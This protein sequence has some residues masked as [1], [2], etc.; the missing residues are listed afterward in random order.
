M[1]TSSHD[2]LHHATT[3]ALINAMPEGLLQALDEALSRGRTREELL[4]WAR[5][6]TGGPGPH[7]GGWTYLGIE[8]YLFPERH[9]VEG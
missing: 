8:A 9:T 6:M 7:K 1:S 4:A 2:W 3:N 5:H